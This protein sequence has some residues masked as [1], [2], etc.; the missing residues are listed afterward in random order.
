MSHIHE[1]QIAWMD[2]I[3]ERK[4]PEEEYD[5]APIDLAS[6]RATNAEWKELAGSADL[7]ARKTARRPDGSQ[8]SFRVGDIARHVLNHGTYH[9]GHLRGLAHAEGLE[10]FEDT[11]LSRWLRES[12]RAPAVE[13]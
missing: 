10:D 1:A 12:G 13:Q 8:Y 3:Q 9:R 4:R 7:E 6:L 2:R 11:D 5:N